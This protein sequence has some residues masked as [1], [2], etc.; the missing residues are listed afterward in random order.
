MRG[1]SRPGGAW[2]AVDR[3]PA[4]SIE[5]VLLGEKRLRAGHWIDAIQRARTGE[6]LIERVAAVH[7]L[8]VGNEDPAAR[9]HGDA[10]W[11]HEQAARR[12]ATGASG[13]RVDAP[14]DG[15]TTVFRASLGQENI[16]GPVHREA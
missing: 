8:V 5:V 10:R 12:K 14:N 2:P 11:I 7:V 13:N 1:T 15:R 16:P 3:D 6:R 4:G 9:V